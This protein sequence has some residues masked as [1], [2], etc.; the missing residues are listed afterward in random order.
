MTL[1][2]SCSSEPLAAKLVQPSALTF[3]LCQAVLA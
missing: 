3:T 2:W 1:R